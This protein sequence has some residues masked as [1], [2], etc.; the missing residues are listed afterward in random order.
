[1][2]GYAAC[3]EWQVASGRGSYAQ[4]VALCYAMLHEEYSYN[5]F[6]SCAEAEGVQA[7]CDCLGPEQIELLFGK[8]Q[9]RLPWPLT[10]ED[11]QAGYQHQLSVWQM[12]YSRTDV[13]TRPLRGREFFE[14]VIRENIDLGRP[15]SVQLVFPPR[16]QKNTPGMFRTRVITDG[17][18]PSLHIEYKHTRIKQYFKESRALRTETTLNDA[19]DFAKPGTTRYTLTPYGLRVALFVTRLHARLLRPGFGA[20]DLHDA[21]PVPHALRTAFARVDAEVQRILDQAHIKSQAEAA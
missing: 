9:Q 1:M 8:W 12:E 16:I 17:V 4:A 11:R 3:G 2:E 10:E 18:A 14:E 7:I 15:D 19:T 13:F 6:L 20:I 21:Q 5:G